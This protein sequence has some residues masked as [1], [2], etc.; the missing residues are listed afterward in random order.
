MKF[1]SIWQLQVEQ[2]VLALRDAKRLDGR[3]L[4]EMR[5]VK[6]QTKVSH[7]A[8]GSCRV[9]LGQTDVVAGV[10]CAVGEP[11]SDT[12][13]EGSISVS[14]EYSP[15]ASPDFESGPP[16]ADSVEMSRVVDR[17]IR[18]SKA[19]DF[20]KWSIKD[21]EKVWSV[22]ADVYTVNFAGNLYDASSIAVLK[23]LQETRFPKLDANQ[24]PQYGEAGEKLELERLPLLSTFAKVGDAIV[25]DPNLAEEKAMS[26]RFSVAVTEDG[27]LTAFQKGG[28]KGSFT[29]SEIDE[30]IKTAEKTTAKTRKAFF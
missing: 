4:D 12:P 21:K 30:C 26:C 13:N 14:A 2:V 6:L 24:T 8:E 17:G 3:K 11:F 15:M 5:E 20:E 19:L 25:L 16:S 7:N 9:S 28:G 18:E 1:N 10:K 23:A 22:F 29:K 27:F